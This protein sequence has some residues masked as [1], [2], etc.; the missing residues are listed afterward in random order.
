MSIRLGT[1]DDRLAEFSGGPQTVL[2]G[3]E[4][5]EEDLNKA[6]D[7]VIGG[8]SAVDMTEFICRGHYGMDGVCSWIK[9]CI[10]QLDVPFTPFIPRIER[11]M[12]AMKLVYVPI[13]I[14]Q[15]QNLKLLIA[16]LAQ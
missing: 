1:P 15:Q 5:W 2:R 12:E 14:E 6:L 8:K 3:D 10:T 11:F 9:A 16:P 4:A 13:L 7:R